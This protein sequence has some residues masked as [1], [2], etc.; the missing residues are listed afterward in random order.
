MS[1]LSEQSKTFSVRLPETLIADVQRRI[2]DL[3]GQPKG[4][5]QTSVVQT[6]LEEW[7]GGKRIIEITPPASATKGVHDDM[8]RFRSILEDGM[9]SERDPLRGI[10]KT[11]SDAIKARISKNPTRSR[12]KVQ[13]KKKAG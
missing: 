5:S 13:P 1:E 7:V 9:P 10:I 12:S 8:E 4:F 11:V 2:I 3:G 6:L